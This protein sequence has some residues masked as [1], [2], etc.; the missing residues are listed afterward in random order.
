MAVAAEGHYSFLTVSKRA[1]E[2]ARQ[3]SLAVHH[4]QEIA[5]YF[6][7]QEVKRQR[8]PCMCHFLGWERTLVS[9][10]NVA[11]GAAEERRPEGAEVGQ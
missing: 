6:S 7:R 10:R 3:L 8:H 5:S 9:R 11:R 2:P 1:A 4:L